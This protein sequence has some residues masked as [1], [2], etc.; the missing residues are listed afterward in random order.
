M[1]ILKRLFLYLL[2]FIALLAIGFFLGPKPDTPQFSMPTYQNAASLAALEA[3]INAAED[4]VANLKEGTRAHIV[5]A[6]SS[7]KEKTPIAILYLHGFGAA[8]P[9]G[10][11]VHRNLAKRFGCNLYLARLDD[12]GTEHPENN[13]LGFNAEEYV[14]TAERALHRAKQLG[15]SVVIVATSAG[16]AMSL[17]LASRH[18]EIKALI[19]YSPAIRVFRQDAYLMLGHWGLNIAHW[20]AGKEHNDFPVKNEANRKYWTNHQRFEGIQQF[21]LFQTHTMT[22][23]TFAKVKCP[24][25]MGYYYENEEKQDKVVSVAA[26]K[27]MFEQIATPSNQK[28][29]VNFPKA[30]SHVIASEYLSEDWQS[31]ELES[32]KFMIEVL[33]L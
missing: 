7:R 9:E 3:E 4:T 33:K 29:A 17:F 1:T 30:A 19:T 5:W 22:P 16:G 32:A 10:Q 27:E 12:H 6:D 18:P 14:E 28:R 23:E 20:V 11:P 13:L 25:F 15:D 21:L 2:G 31:V 8:Y 26:M 24:F